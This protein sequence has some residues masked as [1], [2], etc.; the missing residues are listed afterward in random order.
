MLQ[1]LQGD[2]RRI[3]LYRLPQQNRR[4]SAKSILLLCSQ[5]RARCLFSDYSAFQMGL[6][7][8]KKCL[9]V[10]SVN[11]TPV[12]RQFVADIGF[13]VSVRYIFRALRSSGTLRRDSAFYK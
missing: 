11:R 3:G 5:P 1:G 2:L 7:S 10:G 12:T 9:L 4:L 13:L 8:R 6:A